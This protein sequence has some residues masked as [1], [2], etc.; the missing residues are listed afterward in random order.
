MLVRIWLKDG[1]YID[2]PRDE[3]RHWLEDPEFDHSEPILAEDGKTE[4]DS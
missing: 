3:A 1:N 2:V 4:D